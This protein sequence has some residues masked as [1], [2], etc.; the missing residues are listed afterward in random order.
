MFD[1]ETSFCYVGDMLYSGGGC[2][3]AFDAGCYVGW[4]KLRKTFAC[5]LAYGARQGV[6]GLCLLGYAPKKW[7]PNTSD[8]QRRRH[9][10]HSMMH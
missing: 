8:L 10:D 5:P 7:G 9:I 3:S 6:H 2:D 4:V 1:A